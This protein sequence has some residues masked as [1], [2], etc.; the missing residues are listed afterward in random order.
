MKV[1]TKLAGGFSLLIVMFAALL[2][3]HLALI[4]RAVSANRN[5]SAIAGRLTLS[6][7]EQTRYLDQLDEAFRKY[8]TSQDERYR[9]LLEEAAAGFEATLNLLRSSRLT[10]TERA[11]LEDLE[12]SWAG[13]A[14]V[15]R[16]PDAA[17]ASDDSSIPE[18]A[19]NFGLQAV[20]FEKR[21]LNLA[22]QAAM[23][24]EVLGT[25]EAAN[26]A[27]RV[28]LLA[29]ALAGLIGMILSY[30]IVRSITRPLADLTRATEAVADG[31]FSV[32]VQAARDD[33][34]S[35]LARGFNYMTQRLSELDQIK[36][37]LISHVSHELKTP[38][39]SMQE[40]NQLM[41]DELP[42]ELV[43]SQRRLLMLNLQSGR[44]LASMISRLLS[45]SRLDAGAV[46]YDYQDRDLV[47]LLERVVQEFGP[48]AR[49]SGHRVIRRFPEDPV[50]AKCDADRLSEAVYNL[51]D[52]AAKFSPTDTEIH[53]AVE[54]VAELPA[55]LPDPQRK[56]M[57]L[58]RSRRA[59]EGES[60]ALI[61]VSDSGPGV[62]EELTS[63]IFERF[64]Q[65]DSARAVPGKGV[66][67]GLA[68]AKQIVRAHA[69]GI[70][71]A[72]GATGGATFYVALPTI[73]IPVEKELL[74]SEAV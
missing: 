53:I 44:R 19:F 28:S 50:W 26:A 3:N 43:E 45:M 25:A 12:Q 10:E 66:G 15:A 11:A 42:G 37:D 52:N 41:L 56:S 67:L 29:L 17:L 38:L 31:D 21:R 7:A 35:M 14:P 1:A 51:L 62:P 46:V 59:A 2:V 13:I 20:R 71:V 65:A 57:G 47:E 58:D 24:A 39:A 23:S 74:V 34:F 70:W 27:E 16:D 48:V 69:G 9:L 49:D 40:T 64:F 18:A 5:L 73:G 32:R 22:T 33:E 36:K 63:R 68:L 54:R 60:Y 8:T 4:N 61:S 6:A 55:S 72:D 30:R